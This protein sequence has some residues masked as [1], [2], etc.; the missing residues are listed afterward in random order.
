MLHRH[1]RRQSG[2]AAVVEIS[3]ALHMPVLGIIWAECA[4]GT[5]GC[6]HTMVLVNACARCGEH[7][8]VCAGPVHSTSQHCKDQRPLFRID[9][10][11]VWLLAYD[12]HDVRCAQ[13][14]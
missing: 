6:L 2:V 14:L 11:W 8:G 9:S 5:C 4:G 1:R 12:V 10:G 13:E 7:L 3:C